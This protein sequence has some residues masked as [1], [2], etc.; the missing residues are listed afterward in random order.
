MTYH[1][2]AISDDLNN[3]PKLP[4]WVTSGRAETLEIV[5]FQS[6]AA[7]TVL[8]QLVSDQ[9]HG[10]P[11]KLLANKLA[12]SAATATSKLEGRL[13]WEAD[14]RDAYHLSPPGEARGPDGDLL[15]FWRE[16]ARLRLTGRE[17]QAGLKGLV[18]PE[19]ETEID[20]WLQSAANHS[21]SH[22]LLAGCVVVMR[23][24]LQADDRAER[25]ACVLSD[26]FLAR[27]L[28]WST[29]LPVSAGHLTKAMLRDLLGDGQ[30]ADLVVQ[31]RIYGP[32]KRHSDWHGTWHSEWRCS[33]RWLPSS[34]QR[35]R[36]QPSHCF[37]LRMLSRPRLC[38]PQ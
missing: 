16:A 22:G 7:L 27:A 29:A 37:C 30:G 10:V 14:I 33:K 4:S 17:W 36:M 31:R 32:S 2:T 11:I 9:R 25:V 28:N 38:C 18:G 3:L 19:F 21:Q 24:V 35:D 5:A 12:L 20:G 6:G 34:G 13:A 1:P 23:A 15:A 8:D 26:I